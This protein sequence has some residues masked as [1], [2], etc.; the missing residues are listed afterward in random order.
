VLEQ[1]SIKANRVSTLLGAVQTKR[2]SVIRRP[3]SNSTG[4]AESSLATADSMIANSDQVT[5]SL[6]KQIKQRQ[7]KGGTRV[8]SR[9]P[10]SVSGLTS[11]AKDLFSLQA[12]ED[13]VSQSHVE[14][15]NVA[16]L[17]LLNELVIKF[18]GKS[19]AQTA[20]LLQK[21]YSKFEVYKP[22]L[23]AYWMAKLDDSKRSKI[24]NI[25]KTNVCAVLQ[26]VFASNG[27]QNIENVRLYK[28]ICRQMNR[29]LWQHGLGLWNCFAPPA[30]N[31]A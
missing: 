10:G 14:K 16:A 13:L 31:A 8:A 21:F 15:L 4:R 29:L 3:D 22:K 28:I 23:G 5:A 20:S 17:K 9:L 7:S 26:K 12:E 24:L 6:L 2:P 1:E 11:N 27:G 30:G 25:V 19:D 18:P